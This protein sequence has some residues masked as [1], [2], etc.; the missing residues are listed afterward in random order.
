MTGGGVVDAGGEITLVSVNDWYNPDWGGGYNAT[1]QLTLTDDMLKGGSVEGWSLQVGISNAN[2]TISTGWLDGFNGTVSFDP[3]TGLFTNAGQDYQPE[4]HA[5]DTILFSVQVQNIGFNIEDFSF[6]FR[7]IDPGADGLAQGGGAETE[8]TVPDEEVSTGG[9]DA[10]DG[11]S[12][13]VAAAGVH[14]WGAGE[15]HLAANDSDQTADS[16]DGSPS[17][18]TTD[19]TATS[20]VASADQDTSVSPSQ[21]SDETGMD[22]QDTAPDSDPLQ[23]YQDLAA[24]PDDAESASSAP[25]LPDASDSSAGNAPESAVSDHAADSDTP[26]DYMALAD[27][28]QSSPSSPSEEG[29]ASDDDYSQLAADTVSVDETPDMPPTDQLL[30]ETGEETDAD[31]PFDPSNGDQPDDPGAGAVDLDDDLDHPHDGS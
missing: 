25:S 19:A 23:P 3:S 29:T 10:L 24:S 2:A 11:D 28:D 4:L 1:F 16:A 22:D 14:E 20:D 8:A 6:S 31:Q 12:V 26:D 9:G 21:E 7:N 27:P 18:Q 30:T 13:T 5:G 15:T 17:S